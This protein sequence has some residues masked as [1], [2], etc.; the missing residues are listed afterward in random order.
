MKKFICLFTVSLVL[1]AQSSNA[2]WIRSAEPNAT[3]FSFAATPKVGGGTNLFAGSN[4]GVFSSTD[5]GTSWSAANNGAPNSRVDAFA[6]IGTNLF[7]TYGSVFLSNNNGSSWFQTAIGDLGAQALAVIDT[8]IYA[9]TFVSGIFRSSDKGK[10][11]SAVNSGLTGEALYITGLIASGKNLFAGTWGGG[12]YRSTNNGASWTAV[13]NGITT[14]VHCFADSPNGM[15]GTNLFAGTYFGE[16][17]YLSTDNGSSWTVVSLGLTTKNVR[18]LAVSPNGSG[19][20]NLFAGTDGGGVFLSTNNGTSWTSVNTGLTSFVVNG[21][22]VSGSYLFAGTN[23]GIWRRRLSDITNDIIPAGSMVKKLSSNQFSFTEG[24]VWYNDSV[25]LFVD[26]GVSGNGSDIYK[27]DPVT[28]QFSKWPSN[29]T[30]CLGLTC[31]K[32]GNLIG[33]S[34]NILMMNKSGQL[35]KTLASGYNGKPFNNPN[36]LIADNKGGVYFT[37]PDYGLITLPQDKTAVYYIDPAGNVKRVIDDLAKPNGLVLSPDGTM[38]YVLDAATKY[39]YSWNVS[40]DGSVSGKS[41]FAEL[42][43]N[44]GVA[45]GDGIAI[46]ING[47]I[48]VATEA[49][50]QIFTAHGAAIT[51]IVLPEMPSNCD[52]GGKDFK[53]LYITARTN[54]Y[55]IEL[56]FPGFAVS[57]KNLTTAVN[58][59]SNQASVNVYPN[60]FTEITTI[61]YQL[62][63]P[64]KVKLWLFDLSG[65]QVDTLIDEQQS[66]GRHT[67]NWDAAGITSGIYYYQ[68]QTGNQVKT[69]K[70]ILTR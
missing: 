19:G 1:I 16:G 9:G 6:V 21:L 49:G 70:M 14:H 50:L 54:L 67:I 17:V 8:N 52:F 44:N 69:G 18:T 15:G 33:C 57:R 20:I 51:T 38:L 46:D 29:S 41:T 7:A 40:P 59:I 12:A 31:D 4:N 37:D 22:F 64:E 11:W 26:D 34:S 63:N 55:S 35:I 56:N 5:N 45:G 27:Y 23:N 32:D 3:F 25:L 48:Y 39:M 10:S 60:P 62:E 43:T 2:Q 65:R 42:Q 13:N 36:D 58:S 68:L 24:P 66:E 61:E 30:H 53:T 47:N 28:K